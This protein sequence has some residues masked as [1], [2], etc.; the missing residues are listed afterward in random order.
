MSPETIIYIIVSLY[1][2][3]VGGMMYA[4]LKYRLMRRNVAGSYKEPTP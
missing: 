4:S 2:G 1:A 3:F